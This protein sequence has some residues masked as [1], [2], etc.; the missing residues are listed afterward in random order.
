MQDKCIGCSIG[1]MCLVSEAMDVVMCVGCRRTFVSTR[2]DIVLKPAVGVAV[3]ACRYF[4]DR[5]M[6]LTCDICRQA[7]THGS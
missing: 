7:D 6:Y 4:F 3:P 1:L 2:E 5:S